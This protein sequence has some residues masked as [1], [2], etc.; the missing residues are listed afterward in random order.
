M[1]TNPD[2]SEAA[3]TLGQALAAL[4][5]PF[6]GVSLGKAKFVGPVTAAGDH[7]KI[8]LKPGYPVAGIGGAALQDLVRQTAGEI[9]PGV[10]ID[11]VVQPDLSARAVQPGVEAIAGVR[12][13]IAIASG[14]GGVGK[15]TTA[16][17]LALAL[18]REGAR[19]GILDADIYGPSQPHMLGASDKPALAPGDEKRILPVVSHGLQSISIGYL[20]DPETPM[21]W[22]GPMATG[23]LD[24]L[25]RDTLWDDLDYLVIDLPPGTGDI[26]LTMAQRIPVSGAVIVTTPQDIALL[27]AVKALRM[28]Q[29]VKIHTLGVVENMSTHICSACGHEEPLFGQGGGS[30]MARQ[31]DIPLLGALPL[32]IRIRQQTDGGEPTVVADPDGDLAT[33]YRQIALRVAAQLALRGK[34]HTSKFGKISVVQE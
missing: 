18:A 20:I 11:L 7:L 3:S 21:V 27:D 14:K 24:Q 15:S 30:A 29:K 13:V 4:T 17:N 22:R 2:M 1:A 32:D 10:E 25:C 23:A 5:D 31:N 12:N 26:Q 19:T 16:V 8:E 9:V 34:D 33:Q 6:A 28:F